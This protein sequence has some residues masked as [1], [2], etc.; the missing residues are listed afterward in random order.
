[1]GWVEGSAAGGGPQMFVFICI[2]FFGPMVVDVPS[3]WLQGDYSNCMCVIEIS[4]I[5][6]LKDLV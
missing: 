2:L 4:C 3:A 6:I 5:A 1:M